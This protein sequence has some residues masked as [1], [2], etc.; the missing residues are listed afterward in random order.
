MGSFKEA[1]RDLKETWRLIGEVAGREKGKSKLSKSLK[2]NDSLTSDPNVISNE[3]NKFFCM[4]GPSLAAQIPVNNSHN[5]EFYLG[6]PPDSLF[7]LNPISCHTLLRHIDA[8]KPKTSYGKDF[9]SNKLLK[10]AAPIL[11][12]PLTYLINLS[13]ST[14]VVPDEVTISKVIPLLKEGDKTNF[15]NYRPIAIVSSIGKLLERVVAEQLNNYLDSLDILSIHQFGFRAGHNISHPLSHFSKKIFES[16]NNNKLNLTTLIDL[17]KAF[18]TVDWTI[19]LAKLSHYGVKNKEYAWF[20]SY[21]KRKQQVFAGKTLSEVIVMLCGIPQGTCLGPALFI[22]FINDLPNALDLFCQLF[23]DDCTLQV[24]G[25][26][27]EELLIKTTEQLAIAQDWFNCNRLTLNLKKTK[28]IVFANKHHQSTNFP[29]LKLGGVEI[30]RVGK[31]LPEESARFLGLWVDDSLKFP[32]H[33]SKLKAKINT[34]LYHLSRAK[35]NSP[36]RVRLSIYRALVESHLRFAC[37][38]YGSAPLAQL[39]ELLI[40]QKKAVR[41]ILKAYYQAHADP[42]FLKLKILKIQDLILFERALTVH[43][44]RS[45]KLPNSFS[46]TYFEFIEE[47]DTNRRNDPLLLKVPTINHKHLSRNPY[48][49]TIVAWNSLPYH[50]KMITNK[51]T[52]KESLTS[53]LL[54]KY[55]TI[56]SKLNCRS[57]FFTS[58]TYD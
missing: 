36:L 4:T 32:S 23:A 15:S 46:R 34:G 2:I 7:S 5:F 31:N 45:R 14:G 16:L 29:P 9:V 35:E 49:M 6:Q 12:K 27:I 53:Y 48:Y 28:F 43:N 37:T 58:E 30:T 50:I 11:L 44:F 47:N 3:F 17:R 1:K 40:L 10:L 22:L 56:C 20:V 24:E 18:E 51:V 57:C 39:E 21:L 54:D 8:L 26:N 41:H 38:S 13:M 33:I 19:L 55:N 42:L 25:D 52:F